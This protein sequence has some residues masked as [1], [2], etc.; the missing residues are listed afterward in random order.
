MEHTVEEH[1][2]QLDDTP[3]VST[4][5]EHSNGSLLSDFRTSNESDGGSTEDAVLTIDEPSERT[6]DPQHHAVPL[7]IALPLA[8]DLFDPTPGRDRF[9]LMPMV[10]L[11]WKLRFVGLQTARGIA[12]L[13]F[14]D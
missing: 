14:S 8:I 10:S 2:D 7:D 1:T 11:L 5:D 6:N 13:E 9:I 3:Q 12:V 4:S